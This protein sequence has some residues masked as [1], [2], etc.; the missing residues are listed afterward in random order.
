MEPLFQKMLFGFAEQATRESLQPARFKVPPLL[1]F[2]HKKGDDAKI[3]F[4]QIKLLDKKVLV[5]AH[6]PLSP[7]PSEHPV[8]LERTTCGIQSRCST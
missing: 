2:P 4:E 7:L 8:R 5:F 1:S 6:R 3:E